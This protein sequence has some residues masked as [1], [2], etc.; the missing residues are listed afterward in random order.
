MRLKAISF[1]S[2]S[3]TDA[4]VVERPSENV[5]AVAACHAKRV[6]AGVG[7]LASHVGRRPLLLQPFQREYLA[8][9]WEIWRAERH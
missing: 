4:T 8:Q 5:T 3:T 2:R 9:T 1:N 6:S 7:V